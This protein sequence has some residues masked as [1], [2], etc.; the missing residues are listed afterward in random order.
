VAT[1]EMSASNT[2]ALCNLCQQR[3]KAGTHDFCGQ[4]CASKAATLCTHC[5]KRP[6]YRGSDYCGKTCRDA[7]KGSWAGAGQPGGAPP[8][9]WSTQPANHVKAATGTTLC[10]Q[11]NKRPKYS[12]SDY[13]GKTCRDA[14]KG[15]WGGGAQYG[16]A[17]YGGAQPGGA[18]PGGP[19]T[20]LAQ[21]ANH[22]KNATG[23]GANTQPTTTAYAPTPPTS[24]VQVRPAPGWTA[25]Q[26]PQGGKPNISA[27]NMVV[28]N[29]VPPAVSRG[30]KA[31]IG[32]FRTLSAGAGVP[33]QPT[34]PFSP[35]SPPPDDEDPMNGADDDLP[36]YP[37]DPM[38][39]ADDDFSVYPEEDDDPGVP[40]CI[41]CQ[42]VPQRAEDYFCGMACKKQA[43]A[44]R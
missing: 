16:G 36:E 25:Y 34:Q 6:K 28:A 26:K 22:V 12:G 29:S 37:E 35:T 21:A 41:M 5:Y 18:Q 19:G 9:T 3:P 17:Q 10:T 44:K 8:G 33:P 13:C 23:I 40:L 2:Q 24:P 32:Q 15:S 42:H 39:G 27:P 20:W 7:A 11:C 30:F 38:N 14:A 1:S 43:M 4:N 31:P